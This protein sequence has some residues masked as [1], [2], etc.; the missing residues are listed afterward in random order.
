MCQIAVVCASE[1]AVSVAPNDAL[2]VAILR[3]LAG[4]VQL[5]G[6]FRYVDVPIVHIEVEALHLGQ[7]G[8][9]CSL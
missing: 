5:P 6:P 9:V 4:G 8:V 3:G 2:E 7:A 1:E